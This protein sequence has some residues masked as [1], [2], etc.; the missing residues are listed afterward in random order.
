ME[1]ITSMAMQFGLVP[2][3]KRRRKRIMK[4]GGAAHV[5]GM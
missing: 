5:S 1:M 3:G 2:Q 4:E